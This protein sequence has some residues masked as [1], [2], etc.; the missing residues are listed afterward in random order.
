MKNSLRFKTISLVL[1]TCMCGMAIAQSDPDAEPD[2]VANHI[3]ILQSARQTG[4]PGTLDANSKLYRSITKLGSA[5]V[6]TQQAAKELVEW[7]PVS[8]QRAYSTEPVSA[9]QTH[10]AAVSL[11]ALGANAVTALRSKL[12]KVTT[13]ADAV[14]IVR[15]LQ[16]IYKKD[17]NTQLQ[18]LRHQTSS[19]LIKQ[20]IDF[21]ISH[22]REVT[23]VTLEPDN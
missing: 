20:A 8:E 12:E 6:N 21:V 22:P 16:R 14:L 2:A 3:S 13:N 10:P 7:L 1:A 23:G 5:E 15:C 4:L 11:I 9:I 17:G 19:V 18:Q